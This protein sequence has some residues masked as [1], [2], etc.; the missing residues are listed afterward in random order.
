MNEAWMPPENESAIRNTESASTHRTAGW[1]TLLLLCSV[2]F[3]YRLAERDLW[4]SHEARAAQDAQTILDDDDWGLPRLFDGR[5]ELQKPP[6][7]YWT[8]AIVARCFGAVDA[9]S[10]RLPSAL[11]AHGCV[12]GIYWFGLRRG[13]PLVGFVAAV[14][15]ATAMHFTWLARIARTDMPLT[16]AIALALWCFALAVE[17]ERPMRRCL[18]LILAYVALAVAVLLKGP[19]GLALPCVVAL[20]CIVVERVALRDWGRLAHRLGLWWGVPLVIGIALPWFVW[21]NTRTDGEVFRTF[22]WHHNIER[23]F[24]GSDTLRAHPWWF[25]GPQFLLDFLPWSPLVLAAGWWAWR[26]GWLSADREAR[27]GLVW[28]LA[29]AALLSC[30]RFKRSDYLAPAYPGAALF[31]GAAAERWYL[32]TR[33]RAVV[34][35]AFAGIVAGCLACWV[36]YVARVL[37]EQEETREYRHFAEVIRRYAPLPREVVFFRAEAHALAFHVGRPLRVFVEWESL[38]EIAARPEASFVVMPAASAREWRD[39]LRLGDLE[40]VCRNTE[41]SSPDHE[42]PLVLFRTRPVSRLAAVR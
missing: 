28:F 13:R 27:L 26:R 25:Y 2:L 40:E 24:G 17:D 38:D 42:R 41:V 16:L 22:F 1:L 6:L 36:T 4:N 7:Y 14:V 10:V 21:A 33:R 32:A 30:A 11:A 19:I 3:F 12:L 9:W 20:A 5:L 18:R 29:M 23:G 39:H 37:P 35:T 34:A 8:V 15:L 31:L